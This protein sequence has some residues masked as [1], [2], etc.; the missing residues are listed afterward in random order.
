MAGSRAEAA[1]IVGGIVQFQRAAAES[2]RAETCNCTGA[3]EA[4]SAGA[5]G[6]ATREGVVAGERQRATAELG[7]ADVASEVGT[8]RVAPVAGGDVAASACHVDGSAAESIAVGA[9]GDRVDGRDRAGDSHIAGGPGE[10][11][12]IIAAI[13]PW[14]IVRNPGPAGVPSPSRVGPSCIAINAAP[15][16]GGGVAIGRQRGYCQG[17]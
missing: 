5:N 17:A 9:K 3:A 4:Q 1:G 7:Q 2:D 14:L 11:G 12:V 10:V 6:R 8:D 16:K 15:V 13:T